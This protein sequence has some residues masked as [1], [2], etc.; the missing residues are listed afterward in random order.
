[1]GENIGWRYDGKMKRKILVDIDVVAV[2]KHYVKDRDYPL[3]KDF[4]L[5]AESG[6]FEQYSAHTLITLVE[7][8]K[9]A[10]IRKGILDFCSAYCYSIPKAEVERRVREKEMD[11][12]SLLDQMKNKGVKEEDGLLALIASLFGLTVVT[13][14]R[15]HLKG[16]REEINEILK[17]GGL[18]EIEI[19]LPNEV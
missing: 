4:I 7:K 16:K 13:L 3:A 14:N 15:K 18:N 8:W 1:M 19:L 9:D 6:E 2:A 5:K 17:G 10:G 12:E 11:L